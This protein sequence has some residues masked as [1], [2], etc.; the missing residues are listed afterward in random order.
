MGLGT[1]NL[2]HLLA[3][4]QSIAAAEDGE[5]IEW[6]RHDRW[7]N[8]TKAERVLDRLS[9]S[10]DVSAAEPNAVSVDLRRSGHGEDQNHREIL[11]RPSI[12]VRRKV[13]LNAVTCRGHTNA[14]C[15]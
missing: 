5:R 7:I 10:T 1:S 8:H 12:G 6:I 2:S 15:P 14:S 11:A 3:G 4:H 13:R 9:E